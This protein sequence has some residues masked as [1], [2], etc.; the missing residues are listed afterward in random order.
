MVRIRPVLNPD[1]TSAIFIMVQISNPALT[2]SM[3]AILGTGDLVRLRNV[4]HASWVAMI[5]A[6]DFIKTS[7]EKEAVNA[8]LP[9]SL[10][11][12]RALRHPSYR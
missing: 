5:A 2:S 6:A 12:V 8:N 10:T 3:K 7:T 11:M 1:G 9:I 4:A